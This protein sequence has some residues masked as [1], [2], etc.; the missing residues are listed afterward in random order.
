MTVCARAASRRAPLLHC[1]PD[2]PT[3]FGQTAASASRYALATPQARMLRPPSTVSGQARALPAAA[4]VLL[5]NSTLLCRAVHA[6]LF[7]LPRFRLRAP[8]AAAPRATHPPPTHRLTPRALPAGLTAAP[9]STAGSKAA[10]ASKHP[11]ESAVGWAGGCCRAP[12]A[13]VCPQPQPLPCS[14]HALAALHAASHAH[15]GPRLAANP[16]PFLRLAH[17]SP[18]TRVSAQPP[19]HTRRK[20]TH[21]PTTRAHATHTH[22]RAQSARAAASAP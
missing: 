21:Q 17:S 22:A 3:A 6:L 5:H 10:A 13:C 11:S 8:A 20:H 14:L 16:A 18:H 15:H 1:P 9:R 19:T 2:P 4:R 12:R 7:L